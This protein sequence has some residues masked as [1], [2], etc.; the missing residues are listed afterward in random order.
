[1]ADIVVLIAFFLAIDSI[2]SVQD[3]QSIKIKSILKKNA[4]LYYMKSWF[5]N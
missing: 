3:W 1:M 5:D 2:G 4:T